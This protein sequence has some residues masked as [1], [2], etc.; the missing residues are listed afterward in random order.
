M[1][2]ELFLSW[3]RKT[4]GVT[5][6]VSYLLAMYAVVR[7]NIVPGKYLAV[8]IPVTALTIAFITMT[9]FKKASSVARNVAL[10]IFSLLLTIMNMYIFSAGNATST[11]LNGVQENGPAYE[12][13]NIIAKKDRHIKLDDNSGLH[14]ALLETDTNSDQVKTEVNKKTKTDYKSY[15]DL[16]NL[17]MALDDK[18]VDISPLKSSYIQLLKENNTAFYQSIEVL[19]TFKIKV[20]S[21][22]SS[23]KTDLSKPFAMYISGIDTYGK[24]ASVSRSDVNILAI[25]N[26]QTH[27]ILLVNTPR[28]Y[29]VQLHGTTGVKDKLTHAGIYGIDMS[30]KTLEDLYSTPID[31]Y[32]RVNF[33]SLLNIVDAIGG[34]SVYSDYDFKA[35]GYSYTAGYNQLDGKQA[36][37]FSRER[38]SFEDGDRTRGKNQ[39]KV[40]EAIIH[41]ISSP[42]TLAN[43]QKILKSL[44]GA[45]QTNVS[46]DEIVKL[47][48]Q[49]LDT[50]RKWQVESISVDGTGKKAVTYSMGAVPLYVMEPDTATIDVAKQKIQQ[51]IA[52]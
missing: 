48:N 22:K 31:Y 1:T 36:L 46:T 43:Y 40:I 27:K 5:L 45:F 44:D 2:K 13:Y 24:I 50:M 21:D 12:E 49:Q 4:S 20:A 29:Y 39:Q 28:D 41:K 3:A 33:A 35:G 10:I 9:H 6:A 23:T 34:V 7:T 32:M 11:F 19:A 14:A 17:T 8:I 30:V 47:M 51:Y 37:A 16:T 18:S 15:T 26:P 38:Y 42:A 52:H 25:V